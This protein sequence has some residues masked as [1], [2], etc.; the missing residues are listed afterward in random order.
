MQF[1]SLQQGAH[2]TFS[3][4]IFSNFILSRLIKASQYKNCIISIKILKNF[5][6]YKVF[7]YFVHVKS[8]LHYSIV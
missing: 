5:P 2:N 6:S 4:L 7:L 1:Q 8:K 3:M